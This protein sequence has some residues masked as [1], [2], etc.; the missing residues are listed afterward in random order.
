MLAASEHKE[1][2]EGVIF[3]KKKNLTKEKSS[4]AWKFGASILCGYVLLI[5]FSSLL[6][7]VYPEE[8]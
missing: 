8:T 7:N 5:I 4:M 3:F 1:H 2:K 6:P